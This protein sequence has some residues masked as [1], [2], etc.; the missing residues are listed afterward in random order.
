MA[1]I[2]VSSSMRYEGKYACVFFW[3]VFCVFGTFVVL[4]A[5]L[6]FSSLS[7]RLTSN[8]PSPSPTRRLPL[9]SPHTRAHTQIIEANGAP[10]VIHCA[11]GKDRTGIAMAFILLAC[12]VGVKEVLDDYELSNVHNA[13]RCAQVYCLHLCSLC[14][15][16]ELFFAEWDFQTGK[17]MRF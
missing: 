9:P 4:P 12:G 13:F 7:R 11:A 6:H 8:T 16:P 5:S 1:P 17:Q 10:V 2:G 3:I 14:L 15:W